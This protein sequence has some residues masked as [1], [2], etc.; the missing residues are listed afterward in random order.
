[1]AARGRYA[2]N[3]IE[4]GEGRVEIFL[5]RHGETEWNAEG[6]YQGT[7]DS[8]LTARGREQA[9]AVGARLAGLAG[10]ARLAASPAGR[11]QQTAAIIAAAHGHAAIETD[12]ALREVSIG[13]W[14]GLTLEDID[15]GWPGQLD[16]TTAFD[17]HFRAPGGERYEAAAE[18]ARRW[19]AAQ[20]RP[21]VAVS[22]GLFGRLLRGAF[23]GLA[24]E[25]A[26]CL[27]VP[28]DAIWHLTPGAV[29]E[30]RA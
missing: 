1:M 17:W 21:V 16:G 14:E 6:R 9:R 30:I 18:R 19:L 3:W 7:L 29:V 15:A 24:R 12:A 27:P 5:C 8:P 13:A 10:G 28:Q 22:H 20:D 26:L 11:A 23:L 25:E 2:K 4:E